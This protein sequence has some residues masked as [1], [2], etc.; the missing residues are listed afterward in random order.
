MGK[1]KAQKVKA[2]D[3]KNVFPIIK[4]NIDKLSRVSTDEAHIFAKLYELGY[5][6]GMVDHSKEQYRQGDICTNTIEGFWSQ[7]KRMI[8]GTHLHVSEK[9]LQ[10]YLDEAG[11]RYNNRASTIPM[12]ERTIN[13][14]HPDRIEA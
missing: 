3:K 2:L 5:D 11:F 12:F 6:H 10:N 9:Y 8:Y 7:I 4:A 14:L 13:L 1:V